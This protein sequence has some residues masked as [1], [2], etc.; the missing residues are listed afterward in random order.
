[1]AV[2]GRGFGAGAGPGAGV[3]SNYIGSGAG[4]GGVGGASSLSPGGGTYGSAQQPVDQGS[5][6]GLGYVAGNTGSEGGGA[7]HL[8]VGGTLTVNGRLSASGNAGLPDDAGGGSGG[9][10]WL[11]AA[12]LAGTG[13]IAAEGGAGE[14]FDG[15]GG[16]GGRIAIYT[17]L[18][19]F[20]G[21]VSAAGG[22]GFFPGEAG[23]VYYG[24]APAVPQVV[25][26]GPSGVIT[27]AVSTAEVVFSAPVNPYSAQSPGVL[28]ATPGGVVVSNVTSTALSP[29]RFELS[30]PAQTAQ[31]DYT[32]TV[33][34]PVADLYGQP[35]SQV[36]TG[37]FSI[38]WTTV[39]GSITN[40][41]GQPVPDVLVQS[42]GG[43]AAATTDTNGNYVLAVPPGGA[44][45][46]TPSKSGLVFVPSS[47]TYFDVTTTITNENYLAVTSAAP[48]LTSHVETNSLVLSW[49]GIPGVSY[50][51]YYSIDMAVWLPY[52][53]QQ[54][55][56]NG[57]LQVVVPIDA[58]PVKFFRV[59]A[60]Y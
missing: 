28:L 15:G 6:G 51:T 9:S 40:T 26:I 25:S 17:P 48:T 27:A 4:Y 2:D 22:E 43:G 3:S 24:V 44:V 38:A 18:N 57:P 59:Q 32:L 21:L 14:L 11:N 13:T 54:A 12:A 35:L 45:I 50:Q 29:Y 7:V 37:M 10:V 33:G 56:T 49:Y 47:R 31:G 39:Q 55:G 23:S 53:N 58:E 52:D 5:G 60:L 36:Y 8:T 42:D 19:V 16:G 41:N 34:P 46:V 30:F 1:M 20:S